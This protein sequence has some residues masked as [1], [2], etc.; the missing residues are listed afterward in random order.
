MTAEIITIGDELLI[1][2]V[3]DTNSAYIAQRLSEWGITL[4]QITSVHDNKEHIKKALA[5]ALERVDLVLCTGGLGPTKDDITKQ[6]FCEFFGTHLVEDERV[7]AHIHQL[8][9][10]RPEVLNR[11]TATQWLVPANCTVIQNPVGSAPIMHWTKD[12]G[13]K[14][15]DSIEHQASSIEIF[16]MPGVPKEMQ[17]AMEHEVGDYLQHLAGREA[18]EHQNIHVKGIPESALAILIEKWENNLPEHLHLAYLPANG[19]I[20]LR[21]SGKKAIADKVNLHNE[22]TAQLE[23]LKP[24]IEAYIIE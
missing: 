21:L 8:Y 9:A 23:K 13:Q 24:I 6:T 2:Q 18:I 12:K 15:K 4:Y 17:Y 3:V 20:C 22:I 19:Q 5:E 1:G 7:K 10:H 14:T 11:L 16:A